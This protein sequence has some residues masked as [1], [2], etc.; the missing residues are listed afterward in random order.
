LS[1]DAAWQQI[2][3]L[4]RLTLVVC[5]QGRF[6]FQ[7]QLFVP[8]IIHSISLLAHQGPLAL[9][10]SLHH[11]TSSLIQ[12]LY[13]ARSDD[14]ETCRQLRAMLEELMTAEVTALFGLAP[15]AA[16]FD[17]EAARI[18][19]DTAITAIEGVTR[20]FLRFIDIAASSPSRWIEFGGTSY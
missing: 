5:N 14:A 19:N 6:P 9:R 16:G 11:M 13:A 8:E 17:Y 20:F 1:E 4:A 12:S 10:T 15:S 3:A 2:A 7:I 18:T